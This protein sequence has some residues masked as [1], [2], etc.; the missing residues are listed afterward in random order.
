MGGPHPASAFIH[1]S[2][3]LLRAADAMSAASSGV[4]DNGAHA[5]NPLKQRSKF[6]FFTDL[7]TSSASEGCRLV[8]SQ[9]DEPARQ[10]SKFRLRRSAITWVNS[11]DVSAPAS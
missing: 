9:L 3:F 11:T 1:A 6:L 4:N 2:R 5:D 8:G 10:F 7:A